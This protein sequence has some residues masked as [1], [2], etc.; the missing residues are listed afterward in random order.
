[1]NNHTTVLTVT[2]LLL[3]CSLAACFSPYE[4][5]VCHDYE[6]F[7]S[8]QIRCLKGVSVPSTE[9]ESD[10]G[11]R[12]L[13]AVAG[14]YGPLP[15]PESR[16]I[17]IQRDY[18]GKRSGMNWMDL[19]LAAKQEFDLATTWREGDVATMDTLRE[20]IDQGCPS[21][22][23]VSLEPL[24]RKPFF[25][26]RPFLKSLAKSELHWVVVVGYASDEAIIVTEPLHPCILWDAAEF[27]TCWARANR[28]MVTV[29]KSLR[30]A[31]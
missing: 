3:A 16:S 27:D 9:L 24:R 23:L 2:C 30:T 15:D 13:V 19:K 7:A 8:G 4:S 25:L 12:A 6:D 22:V 17:E 11:A 1:M 18:C 21:M 10:C 5:V 29:N 31:R 26:M 14:A 20:A 28:T